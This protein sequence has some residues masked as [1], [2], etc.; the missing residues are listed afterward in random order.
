MAKKKDENWIKLY[1]SLMDNPLWLKEPFTYGQAWVDLLMMVCY[2]DAENIHRGQVREISR[3]SIYT[4]MEYLAKRWHRSRK[5]V[6]HYI[7]MLKML[8]MVTTKVTTQGTLIT[9]ENYAS[10]QGQ[11]P[12]KVTTKD[13][14]VVT[15]GV[16]HNK[17]DKE[18][19]KK[20]IAPAAESETIKSLS[21]DGEN[22]EERFIW[23]PG[24]NGQRWLYDT[25]KEEYV[26]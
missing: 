6:R 20:R 7:N 25:E 2:K 24:T 4:S 8:K 5:W 17:K 26:E 3:G 18:S 1:R 15:A 13:T 16:T 12:T 14:A 9:V 21:G 23:V 22:E 10:F 11:G 19:N